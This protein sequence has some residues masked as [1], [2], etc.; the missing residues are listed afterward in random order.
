M[1][2]HRWLDSVFLGEGGYRF[3]TEVWIFL[4]RPG[5]I[6][7]LPFFSGRGVYFFMV[8]VWEPHFDYDLYMMTSVQQKSFHS[9]AFWTILI[10][11]FSST[12]VKAPY[13]SRSTKSSHSGAI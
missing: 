6:D 11:K 3:H 4:F 7:F 1:V 2:L 12:K 10:S 13:G 9:G 8:N 5:G